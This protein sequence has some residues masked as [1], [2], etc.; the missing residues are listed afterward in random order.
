MELDSCAPEDSQGI[1]Y[2]SEGLEY[3]MCIKLQVYLPAFR[4][5]S[6]LV[7]ISHAECIQRGDPLAPLVC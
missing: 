2:C 5:S 3:I 6:L 1:N 4:F 7:A